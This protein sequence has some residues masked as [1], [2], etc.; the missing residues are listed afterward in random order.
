M[1]LMVSSLLFLSPIYEFISMSCYLVPTIRF[2]PVTYTAVEGRNGQAVIVT[3]RGV[4]SQPLLGETTIRL[5][6]VPTP[7]AT[8]ATSKYL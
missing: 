4:T 1:M 6:D 2:Q 7:G 8:A 3:V 5:T